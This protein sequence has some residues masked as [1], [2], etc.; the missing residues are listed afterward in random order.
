MPSGPNRISAA[1]ADIFPAV[2]FGR[3][4]DDGLVAVSGQSGNTEP[5]KLIPGD[6]DFLQVVFFG[7]VNQFLTGRGN[8]PAIL[9]MTLCNKAMLLRCR[10]ESPVVIHGSSADILNSVDMAIV[11]GHFM[12]ENAQ[13]IFNGRGQGPGSDVY[14]VAYSIERNPGIFPGREMPQSIRRTLDG[15]G[16]TFQLII[17]ESS[18]QQVKE[19]VQIFN[20]FCVGGNFFHGS[21]SF[22]LD[23]VKGTVLQ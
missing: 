3:V 19:P 21:V 18:I 13:G 4:L 12:A 2:G 8:R 6:G 22:V 10:F 23:K 11:V 20:G 9:W 16:R 15:D 5:L 17:K 1:R 7:K 14:F